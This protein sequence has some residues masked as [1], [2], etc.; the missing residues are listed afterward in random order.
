MIVLV[1]HSKLN[2]G[3]CERSGNRNGGRHQPVEL[4]QAT[5]L[6]VV[7]DRSGWRCWLGVGKRLGEGRPL[8]GHIVF[9]LGLV[10]ILRKLD[11]LVSSAMS[12][13]RSGKAGSRVQSL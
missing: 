9:I 4:P 1:V 13:S 3:P 7:P 2:N 11:G 5:P 6:L 12:A 10:L 8:P